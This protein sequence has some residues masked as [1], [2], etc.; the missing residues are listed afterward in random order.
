VGV[1]VGFGLQ[2]VVNNFVSGLILLFERPIQVGDS[3]QLG[4]LTGEVKR[5]GIRSSTVRTFDGAE[6][7]VPNANLVSDQV[8][9]WTLSDRMRRI[10]L[11]I[12]IAYGTDPQRVVAVLTE[13]A[14]SSPGVLPEPAPV[15]LFLGF[16]DSALNFQV[17]AWTARFEEWMKTRS[18][19]GLAV[20]MAL[21]AEGIDIPFPQRD[22]RIVREPDEPRALP[23]RGENA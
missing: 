23:E 1:G 2:N 18:D 14:R 20:Q 6:V 5:I 3:V 17:R 10:D 12:G 4:T 8:T 13:V 7:I 19:L 9:N 22:V 16:G 21:R 11:D 15:V